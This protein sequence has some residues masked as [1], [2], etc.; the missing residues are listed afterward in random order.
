[1]WVSQTVSTEFFSFM[2]GMRAECMPD[3]QHEILVVAAMYLTLT[4]QL[5]YEISVINNAP[6]RAVQL[7]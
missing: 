4:I 3:H 5:S 1:M 7:Q 6:R 2:N